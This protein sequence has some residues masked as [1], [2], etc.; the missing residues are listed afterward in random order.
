MRNL[1]YDSESRY[2]SSLRDYDNLYNNANPNS[3]NYGNGNSR[4]KT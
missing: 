2:K 4:I 1:D 3:S